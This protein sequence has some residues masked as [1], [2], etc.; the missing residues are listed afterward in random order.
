MDVSRRNKRVGTQLRDMSDVSD[1][2]REWVFGERVETKGHKLGGEGSRG[3]FPD[4]PWPLSGFRRTLSP[5]KGVAFFVVCFRKGPNIPC[6][7][8][9]AIPPWP[10]TYRTTKEGYELIATVGRI[11]ATAPLARPPLAPSPALNFTKALTRGQVERYLRRG[12]QV[13]LDPPVKGTERW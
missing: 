4:H 1:E 9:L 11:T 13:V 3:P 7:Y 10:V 2:D 8:L 12:H 6:T 5:G